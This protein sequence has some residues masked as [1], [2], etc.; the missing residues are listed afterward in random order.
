MK[1]IRSIES[2]RRDIYVVLDI[3]R[4]F[5]VRHIAAFPVRSVAHRLGCPVC[6]DQRECLGA[7]EAGILAHAVGS[8]YSVPKKAQQRAVLE[9]LFHCTAAIPCTAPSVLL[10]TEVFRHCIRYS[11]HIIIL[12]VYVL[13]LHFGKMAIQE[14]TTR[15]GRWLP[16]HGADPLC[17]K[18]DS[19]HLCGSGP[20]HFP[21]FQPGCTQYLVAEP[22]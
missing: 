2:V 18:P 15:K 19:V 6:A 11:G 13:R 22:K 1:Q 14:E 17:C 16:P 3:F 20:A 10:R 21:R 4:D 5:F 8:C 12:Y 7:F 9:Q